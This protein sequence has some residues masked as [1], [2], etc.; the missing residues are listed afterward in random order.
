MNEW[1]M[2]GWMNEQVYEWMGCWVNGRVD[3]W[4]RWAGK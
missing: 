4:M 2:Y 1:D 3:G